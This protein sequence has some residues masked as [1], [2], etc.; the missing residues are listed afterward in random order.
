MIIFCAKF[1]IL[2]F[3]AQYDNCNTIIG[4]KVVSENPLVILEIS[5]MPAISVIF[6]KFLFSEDLKKTLP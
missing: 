2:I 4:L 5:A 3:Y 6:A 1:K